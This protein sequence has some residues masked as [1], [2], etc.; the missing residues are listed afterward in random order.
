MIAAIALA[1]AAAPATTP[2][3]LPPIERC[4]G[5]AGFDAFRKDL[6]AAVTAQDVAAIRRLAATDIRSSFGGDGGWN[7]FASTWGLDTDPSASKLWGELRALFSLGCA[8]TEAGGR[9]FPSL[10]Q[11]SGDDT[12]PFEL[13]VA[14]RGAG[15]YANPGDTRP[16][17]TLDW[18]SAR[19]GDPVAQSGWVEV[20]LFDGRKGWLRESD[21]ISP[22]GYRLVAER[23][24]GRWLI[25]ALV[26]GD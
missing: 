10:F 1:L 21:A 15:L 18:H 9:V 4:R 2:A 20:T 16:I 25:A 3:R 26:A 17:T 14:R 19:Q 22:L 23:R 11:D 5:D 8:P 6:T 12:D 7:E 24:D 13:V